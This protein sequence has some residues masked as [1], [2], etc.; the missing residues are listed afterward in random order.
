MSSSSRLTALVGL[1]VA[2]AVVVVIFIGILLFSGGGDDPEDQAASTVAA[3]AASTATA[4][5]TTSLSRAFTLPPSFTPT[6]TITPLPQPGNNGQSGQIIPT[7]IPF[8]LTNTFQ[9]FVPTAA[10]PPTAIAPPIVNPSGDSV[11]AVN[12]GIRSP[13]AGNVVAGNVQIIGSAVYPQFLQYTL[14]YG[15]DPNPANL[16]NP[17]G[18]VQTPISNGL[19]GVWNTNSVADGTYQLRLT[20]T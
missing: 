8:V 4:E 18:V 13:L 5:A 10:L 6:V 2:L 9:P 12:I 14:A 15:S 20:V 17:L 19:L 7:Q 16:F 11:S 3:A 1:L